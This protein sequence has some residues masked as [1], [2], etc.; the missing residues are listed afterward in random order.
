MGSCCVWLCVCARAHMH[1]RARAPKLHAHAHTRS[2]TCPHTRM[3]IRTHPHGPVNTH[4][5]ARARA[6]THTSARK[7]GMGLG[8]P[9]LHIPQLE[10][11]CDLLELCRH[12]KCGDVCLKLPRIV[13]TA[14]LLSTAKL[15]PY[16]LLLHS[17]TVGLSI[18]AAQSAQLKA[19]LAQGAR[20]WAV[21]LDGHMS[22][23]AH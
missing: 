21:G 22:N 11:L 16:L 13:E 15:L 12:G 6:R 10:V 1:T 19:K 2:H 20:G 7:A 17:K 9:H 5:R 18:V 8:S 14:F 3:D 23:R 4:A